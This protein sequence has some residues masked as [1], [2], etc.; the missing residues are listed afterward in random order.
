MGTLLNVGKARCP[1]E[2]GYVY[3]T[4][5]NVAKTV[6]QG[7]VPEDSVPRQPVFQFTPGIVRVDFFEM[8]PLCDHR[9]KGRQHTSFGLISRLSGK[10]PTHR[11]V[12][13]KIRVLMRD[14]VK[15]PR[16]G[17]SASPSLAFLTEAAV[18]P[19]DLVDKTG[20]KLSFGGAISSESFRRHR[21]SF[22]HPEILY[23]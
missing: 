11:V 15:K 13:A 19:G 4:D 18:P 5:I 12:V 21:N 2:V 9:E 7:G 17:G 20:F 16:R 6:F 14:A 1:K 23:R 3:T 8:T 10:H 22:Q